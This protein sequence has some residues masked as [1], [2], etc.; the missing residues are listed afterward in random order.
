[1]IRYN[2]YPVR[3][4]QRFCIGPV[5]VLYTKILYHAIKKR[6]K[7]KEASLMDPHKTHFR[8]VVIGSPCNGVTAYRVRFETTFIPDP[9]KAPARIRKAFG[10]A[11]VLDPAD[12][13]L[14]IYLFYEL[15]H[16]SWRP[17]TRNFVHEHPTINLG[18]SVGQ[19]IYEDGG[20]EL[21]D[22]WGKR[23]QRLRDEVFRCVF[24]CN[25]LQTGFV[26]GNGFVIAPPHP[27]MDEPPELICKPPEAPG[28][29]DHTFIPLGP[30]PQSVKDCDF[31][32]HYDTIIL[33]PHPKVTK[34]PV[35]G[36]K[37]DGEPDTL[38]AFSSPII[39]MS[40]EF[41]DIPYHPNPKDANDPTSGRGTI[42]N[43]VNWDPKTTCAS[44]TAFGCTE[45]GLIVVVSMF[46][47]VEPRLTGRN[48]GILAHEMA[49]LLRDEFDAQC[50]V[51]AGGAA[52]TQQFLRGDLPN[53]LLEAGRRAKQA[54]EHGAP[55]VIGP[56]GLGAIFAILQK[57]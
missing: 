31:D 23:G 49:L 13:E 1:M 41:P 52:D 37:W 34:L 33:A 10:R 20:P 35:D 40:D 47:E 7:T 54:T 44:F 28:R 29:Y 3:V 32:G 2:D 30:P 14:R 38:L 12:V 11:V 27:G 5:G 6:F 42:G 17:G 46:E 48:C 9:E 55:E 18:T 22:L 26:R 25:T 51:I 4:A 45:D 24:A 39:L 15:I 57:P 36:T 8:K 50:A 43:E 16:R 53:E 56:R 19:F 21:R